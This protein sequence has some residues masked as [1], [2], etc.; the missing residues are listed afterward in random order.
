[1]KLQSAIFQIIVLMII[2]VLPGQGQKFYLSPSGDD[3]NPGTIEKPLASPGA[4]VLMAREWRKNN[5]GDQPVEIIALPGEYDMLA[6]LYLTDEDSGTPS[7]PLVFR[8]EGSKKPVFRGSVR[9]SGFEK[10]DENLWKAFLPQVAHYDYYFEQL[11]VN[12]RRAKRARSP[13]DGFFNVGKVEETVVEKGTG[14]SPE[15]AVQKI[16]I[17]ASD[18]ASLG[19]FTARDH[20]DA[21]IIF[22]HKWDNTRKRI[23]HYNSSEAAVYIAGGGMKPWNQIDGSSRWMVE[24]FHA[25]LDSP[26]E[27]YL[28]R[29]GYLYYIPLPGETLESTVFQA[30]V[31]K[32]LVRIEG[33]S[34]TSKAGNI[35]FENIS[36]GMAGYRTP[37]LGNDP[38]QAAAELDSDLQ[39]KFNN[40]VNQFESSIK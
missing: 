39:N 18:G 7:A 24:N 37:P 26:G 6:P 21:L 36:F 20:E 12:G 19:T 9:I 22:Y 30:P 34:A 14:R 31:I 4:A 2:S 16:Y 32:E 38:A 10:I 33:I 23:L 29:S 17:S 27:W 25:A 35:R 15:V 13:N 3:N 5:K 40:I 28:D 1:M 8:S 11:Y